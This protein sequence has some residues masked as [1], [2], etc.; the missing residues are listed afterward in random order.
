M[1][2]PQR[3]F[4]LTK[5]WATLLSLALAV[6]IAFTAFS[7]Y[8]TR[9]QLHRAQTDLLALSLQMERYYQQ[10]S[11]Y[12]TKTTSTAATRE[13][14][15]GWQPAT[16]NPFDFVISSSGG[17]HYTLQAIGN[18]RR[19]GYVISIDQ[20]NHRQLRKPSGATRRW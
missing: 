13:L 12:P 4:M 8:R 1:R 16:G 2:R 9:S 11:S 7:A 19:S 20:S 14:F 10:R 18:G 5:L 3:G 17:E 6:V 15:D